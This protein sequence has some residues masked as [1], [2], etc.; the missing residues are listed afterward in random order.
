MTVMNNEITEVELTSSCVCVVFDEYDKELPSEECFGCWSDAL[1]DLDHDVLTPWLR[2]VDAGDG[3][4]V[5]IDGE[6]VG[7]MRRSGSFTVM[8]DQF[9]RTDFVDDVI[10]L[11][12]LDGDFRLVFELSGDILSVRRWSHDEPTGSA[13]F[14]FRFV[15]AENVE[16]SDEA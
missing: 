8:V 2:A 3:D 11:L 6:G 5:K 9:G 14:V 7:W 1:E 10:S 13:V 16:V 15:S 12:S 4:Y